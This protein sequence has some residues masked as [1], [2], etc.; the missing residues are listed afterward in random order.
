MPPVT[1]NIV[2]DLSNF[3]LSKV[4]CP[5]PFFVLICY[6]FTPVGVCAYDIRTDYKLLEGRNC[7]VPLAP[8]ALQKH[9]LNKDRSHQTSKPSSPV[10]AQL[11]ASSVS[12][13]CRWHLPGLSTTSCCSRDERAVQ[14]ADCCL[15]RSRHVSVFPRALGFGGCLC[16]WGEVTPNP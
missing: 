12:T 11:S 7:L 13:S 3:L 16:R 2:V 6:L 14:P 1:R 10:P 15:T 8:L 9:L 5:C 4:T